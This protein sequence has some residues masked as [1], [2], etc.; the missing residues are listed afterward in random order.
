MSTIVKQEEWT[1]RRRNGWWIKFGMVVAPTVALL[2]LLSTCGGVKLI[3]LQTINEAAEQ[4]RIIREES[5]EKLKESMDEIKQAIKDL[6]DR[7]Y[8]ATK[9]RRRHR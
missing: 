9:S 4:H 3:G 8:E 5:N 2:S 6:D 7:V 1:K